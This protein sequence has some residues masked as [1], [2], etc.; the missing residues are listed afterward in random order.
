MSVGLFDSNPDGR[1]P[2]RG[3]QGTMQ[4]MWRLPLANCFA[5]FPC[6]KS[7]FCLIV[8]ELRVVPNRTWGGNGKLPE[9]VLG[10]IGLPS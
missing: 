7:G 6:F 9:R 8:L 3:V 4:V 2:R 10:L 1:A 5:H